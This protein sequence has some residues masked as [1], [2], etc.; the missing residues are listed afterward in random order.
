MHPCMCLEPHA[1]ACCHRFTVA[2]AAAA[3]E[4]EE[5]DLQDSGFE[6]TEQEDSG[7]VDAACE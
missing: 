5:E 2:A 7:D 6:S 4:M 1:H 3:A